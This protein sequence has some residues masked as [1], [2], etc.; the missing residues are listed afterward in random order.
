MQA[1]L[2]DFIQWDSLRNKINAQKQTHE[3]SMFRT[4]FML[5]SQPMIYRIEKRVEFTK[6]V[7]QVSLID[8]CLLR[9]TECIFLKSFSP[10]II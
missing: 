5:L 9:N 6:F 4:S 7:F 8:Y 2:K 10:V 3:I 1:V